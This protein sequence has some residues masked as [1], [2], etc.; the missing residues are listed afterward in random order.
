[1][2]NPSFADRVDTIVAGMTQ[3]DDGKWQMPEGDHDESVVYAANAERRRRDTQSAYTKTTQQLSVIKA[4]R[5][6]LAKDFESNYV[7]SLPRATQIELEELKSTDADAWHQRMVDI[8]AERATEFSDKRKAITDKA[9]T[10]SEGEYRKRA[11]QEFTDAN[12]TL[13]LTDDVIQNDVPPRITK[14]L[15][16]GSISFGDYLLEVKNYLTAGKV[17]G[18][19]D[20]PK[21]GINLSEVPGGDHAD[22]EAQ[23]KA[24]K[25][26]YNDEIF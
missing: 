17:I 26:T 2:E 13:A 7:E 16:S 24:I 23:R 8:K 19:G 14:K 22:P 12:P 4:E 20:T 11:L 1:M 21:P 10:E 5:D 15:E 6:G 25:S 9:K 18:K 3:S